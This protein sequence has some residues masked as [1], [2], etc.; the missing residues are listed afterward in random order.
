MKDIKDFINEAAN[1][2]GF[3]MGA[4]SRRTQGDFKFNAGEKV[5][6]IKYDTDGYNAQLRGVYEIDKVGK[7]SIKLKGDEYTADKK[8]DAYGICVERKKNVYRGNSTLYWVLYNV[9]L[10]DDD[11]IIQLIERGTNSWGFHPEKRKAPIFAAELKEYI[12]ALHK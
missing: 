5:V 10:A 7:S 2:E 6:L 11:D 12:D 8:F 4:T 1:K 3:F 9:D